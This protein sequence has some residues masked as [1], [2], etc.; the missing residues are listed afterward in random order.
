MLSSKS[1][2]RNEGQAF[3]R[4]QFQVYKFGL[5]ASLV[6][7]RIGVLLVFASRISAQC[8]R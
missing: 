3:A 8:L 5:D 1:S 4:V 6:V 7:R 2:C